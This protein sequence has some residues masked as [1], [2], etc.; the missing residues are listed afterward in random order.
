MFAVPEIV[1]VLR[2]HKAISSIPELG[3]G[4]LMRDTVR[5]QLPAG[6]LGTLAVGRKVADYVERIFD[7]RGR[8]IDELFGR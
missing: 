1:E 2:K 3:A 6:W 8:R 5:Y 7:F 4:T